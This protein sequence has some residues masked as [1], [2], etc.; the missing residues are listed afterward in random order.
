M[1]TLVLA[2]NKGGVGKTSISRILSEYFAREGYRILGLDFDPQ[3]NYSRRFLLMEYD[4][5]D[6]DGVY[7]AIH[8]AYLPQEHGEWDGR[9]STA[10]IFTGHPTVPYPSWVDNLEVLPGHGERLRELESQAQNSTQMMFHALKN[11]LDRDDLREHYDLV[12]I[13][14]SPS[15]D[16]LTRSA[17]MTATHLLVPTLLE[18]QST[19]GLVGMLAFW[20]Q[21]NRSRTTPLEIVGILPNRVRQVGLHEGLLEG[22]KGHPGTG[23]FITPVTLADRIAFAESDHADAKPKS[24]FDLPKSSKARLEAEAV[25]HYVHRKMFI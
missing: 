22:L 17:M 7:P 9:S 2:Q 19:E 14:T 21:V 4:P 11:F 10:D 5:A 13:D 18:T 6:P 8:P 24:V 3:C 25:G 12:I 23:R 16:V 15:K 1:R 20:R